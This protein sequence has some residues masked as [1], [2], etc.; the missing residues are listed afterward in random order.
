MWE[1]GSEIANSWRTAGEEGNNWADVVNSLERQVG[2]EQYA[3]R[4]RYNDPG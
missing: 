3:Q 1:W 2:L 4:G